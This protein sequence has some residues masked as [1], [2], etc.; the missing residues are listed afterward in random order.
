MTC[1]PVIFQ[2]FNRPAQTARV[3]SAI[4]SAQPAKLLIVADGPR[5][6]VRGEAEFCA[7]TRAVVEDIDWPCQVL[8]N[9]SDSNLGCGKRA[10]SG[11][12]WA[13]GEVEDAIILEDDCLPDPTFF[14]FCT[15]LLTRYRS[16]ER[17]M[18]IS[19]NNF[20]PE[21]SHPED[22]YYFS[23]FPHN[24]GWA[25]WRRAWRHYDF[26]MA[27]WSKDRRSAWLKS[28]ARN[29]YLQ[30]V[31]RSKFDETAKG[32]IDTWDYQ[33]MY[34]MFTRHGLSIVPN[35]NLVTNIGFGQGAT[36]TSAADGRHVVASQPIVFPL[37]H[38]A[39]IAP[40][41]R[42]DLLEMTHL[43]RLDRLTWVDH[44]QR[45][46]SPLLAVTRPWLR[47]IGIL[48]HLRVLAARLRQ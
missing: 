25:T 41:D 14:R 39:V 9:Y 8:R 33:W 11:F 27:G 29:D 31:W 4:R 46:L 30:D 22:S 20:Q 6:D 19:G 44:M 16:D 5:A 13:F 35:V 34:A 24:W 45:I 18:M 43:Y 28:I 40:D 42:A 23:Q 12:D 15:E 37:S 48:P 47:R 1:A 38:P 21:Q 7:K 36:H 2:I 10:A 3:F 32:Q 17:I 26:K